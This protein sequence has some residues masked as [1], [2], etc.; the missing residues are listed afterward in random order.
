MSPQSPQ[1]V[2]RLTSLRIIWGAM[3]MGQLMFLGVIFA[4]FHP[5]WTAPPASGNQ[6]PDMLFYCSVGLLVMCVIGAFAIRAV[7]FNAN[8]DEQGLIKPQGYV[9]GTIIYMPML[10]GAAFFGL[11]RHPAQGALA[12]HPRRRYRDRT[13]ID[14]VPNGEQRR[15]DER[16]VI[17]V[18]GS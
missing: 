8:R 13:A 6:P 16:G 9:T 2:G 3:L 12:P 18:P 4:V 11:V 17:I 15:R 5:A 7:V 1:T 14:R 10:E